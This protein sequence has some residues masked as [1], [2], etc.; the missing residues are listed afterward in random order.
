M[1]GVARP[2]V[3]NRADGLF[4]FQLRRRQEA[5]P[6]ASPP[7]G[8]DLAGGDRPGVGGRIPD[9]LGRLR[10]RISGPSLHGRFLKLHVR[11]LRSVEVTVE[12]AHRIARP[13][14]LPFDPSC[15][16][17]KGADQGFAEQGLEVL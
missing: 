2:P 10:R 8:P 9:P 16:R 17:M 14:G 15:R 1:S 7:S 5:A 13:V 6:A 12:P 4:G 11:R 3:S